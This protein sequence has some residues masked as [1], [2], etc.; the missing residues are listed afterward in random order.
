VENT[1]NVSLTG[2]AVTDAVAQ[3]GTS[4]ALVLGAPTGDTDNDG[5]L[6]VDE[7]WAYTVTYAAMQSHIDNGSDI[8]N[9][10]TFDA[11]E[12][13]SDVSDDATTTIT[14][15]PSVSVEKVVDATNIAVPST[16]NYTITVENTGNVSLT[17][18]AVTDAVSQ[19]G[20]STN[21][22]LGA[23]SGDTDNDG[24]LDV[25]E[26]WT[27]TV[28]YAA[29]QSHIDNG[30]DIVNT[31]TF[32]A[33][34][35]T[36]DVSD[37]AT[38][39]ITQSASVSVEKVVDAT[40]ISVPS[41]LTYTITVEN[42]GN[43]SLTGIAVT[44]AVAQDGTS[45]ALVLGAPTGDADND[46]ELDVDETWAY[47]VTYAATQSHIDNGSDIVNV[48]TF[49][50]DELTS[51]VSDDATT[52]ITQSPSVS[53]EKVVDAT[54]IA[55][56]STLNYTITVENTGNVSLTGVAVTDAVSQ[57]GTSTTLALGAPSGDADNDGELDVDE[58]WAYTVTYAATQSHIDNGSDIVNTF[59]FDAD[60][61]GAP[62]SDDA[63]TAI[64]QSASVS[65]EKV[66]DATNI[67]TPSTLTYT[68]TVENTGNVSLTG[69]AVIDAVAQDGTSAALVLGAPTGD[70]DN[71][72]ELDVDETWIY[73]VTYAVTQSHIDNGSDIVNVFTFDAD[74]LTSD[75]SDD[76]TTAIT[77][78]ASVSVE[79]VVDAT[80]ISAPSTL[81][82]TITV[83]NTGNVSLTGVAV[84][85]AVAQDG[86]ST[87][88]TL[89]AP[90]GDAD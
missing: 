34:E 89:G 29:T 8:V 58:T 77:Q 9:V 66:V 85:D 55:V 78:S 63:T 12:L 42:T 21:L 86:T 67:A 31:F 70:A 76:A 17:G 62:V 54:N 23:P 14:Q 64:T 15:S 33:D 39:T 7:T 13:T 27:Y 41:T 57:D 65:V 60:E 80:N 81:T 90:S 53:V 45:T 59:T 11:D 69:I 50:A 32:G 72:G 88:L 79:K 56:P 43:V 37:D 28:T 4:T 1:G 75:V 87:N 44:D 26:T 25:D 16:L 3:D 46:G 30:S 48:F 20:T 71:D 51:E 36:S 73:T 68:I 5:E 49:D 19:D 40:N 82:Y 83:E 22:T 2:V 61:L 24:E 35:L 10:F 47:T 84:T 18:I 38:T 52:T 6:D 74:E